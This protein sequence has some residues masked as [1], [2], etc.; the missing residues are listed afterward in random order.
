MMLRVSLDLS[1]IIE[2]KRYLESGLE[3]EEFQNVKNEIIKSIVISSKNTTLIAN[4]TNNFAKFARNS[5]NS[6]TGELNGIF[7]HSVF[8][9]V[10]A[11]SD[12]MLNVTLLNIFGR[13]ISVLNLSLDSSYQMFYSIPDNATVEANF[14]FSTS[15]NTNYTLTVY[16]L[17]AYENKTEEINIPVE[18]GKSKY[19]GFFDLRLISERLEQRDKFTKTYVLN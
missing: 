12:T 5:L 13:E 19:V 2:K 4:N 18:I 14:I 10:M 16:Y 11:G 17:T 6:R 1:K 9:I 15:S 7:V 8:P 3:R